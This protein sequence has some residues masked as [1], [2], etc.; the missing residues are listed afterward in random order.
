MA[1]VTAFLGLCGS[2]KSTLAHQMSGVEV[3]DESFFDKLPD[4]IAALRAGKDCAI[5][6]IAFCQ[7]QKREWLE[8]RLKKEVPGTIVVWK[9]IEKDL[10][11]ANQNCRR[12]ERKA[13]KP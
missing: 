7:K 6:E 11:K 8:D 3:F 4:L 12:P 1:T 5:T 13:E 9:P 2:G 10:D